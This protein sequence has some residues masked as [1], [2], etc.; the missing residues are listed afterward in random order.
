LHSY[1]FQTTNAVGEVAVQ[2]VESYLASRDDTFAVQNV[3]ED[4]DWQDKDVD[5]LWF[6]VDPM[7]EMVRELSVEVKADRYDTGNMFAETLSNEETSA[8]GWMLYSKANYL[9][10]MFLVSHEVLILRMPDF[11]AWFLDHETEFEEARTTTEVGEHRYTTVGRLVPI[12][13]VKTLP[14]VTCL[15]V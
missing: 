6:W 15:Q 5:I 1:V 12:E 3:E 14:N 8:P 10:Y 2:R 11:R 7:T 9:F 13:M 4:P